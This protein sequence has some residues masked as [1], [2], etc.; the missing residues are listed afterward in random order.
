MEACLQEH[1]FEHFNS[2]GHSGFLHDVSVKLIDKTD[3]KNPIN[4]NTIGD[5]PSKRWH[6]MVLMLKMIFNLQL[7]WIYSPL[8]PGTVL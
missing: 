6:L 7:T 8:V 5:I 3:A 1:L 2:E 4:E